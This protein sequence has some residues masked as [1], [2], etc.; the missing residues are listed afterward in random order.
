MI[1]WTLDSCLVTLGEVCLGLSGSQQ[2]SK[3]QSN[4]SCRFEATETAT[5]LLFQVGFD[6]F[7]RN[8]T[9]SVCIVGMSECQLHDN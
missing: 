7:C 8:A 6:S 9:T 3:L 2:E 1:V 5:P 4:A